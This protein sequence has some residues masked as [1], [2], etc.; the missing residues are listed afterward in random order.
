MDGRRLGSKVLKIHSMTKSYGDK[1]IIKKFTHD[2]KQGE[3]VGIIGKNG[4]GKTTFVN[5]LA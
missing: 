3:R 4:V 5:I 1:L 2:F